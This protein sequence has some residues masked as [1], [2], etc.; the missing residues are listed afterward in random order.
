MGCGSSIKTKSIADINKT[1]EHEINNLPSNAKTRK[2]KIRRLNLEYAQVRPTQAIIEKINEKVI[3]ASSPPS[4]EYYR[5]ET[6][7]WSKYVDLRHKL[8]EASRSNENP[9]THCLSRPEVLETTPLLG[10]F[11]QG[12]LSLV[13]D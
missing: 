9:S 8:F 13:A 10:S 11:L 4:N 5:T 7:Q 12:A 1:L 6:G 2:E 3:N